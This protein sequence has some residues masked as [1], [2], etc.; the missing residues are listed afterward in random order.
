MEEYFAVDN[1]AA[2]AAAVAFAAAAFVA[3]AATAAAE[4]A[5]AVVAFVAIVEPELYSRRTDLRPS[6]LTVRSSA[7]AAAAV[8][9]SLAENPDDSDCHTAPTPTTEK[10]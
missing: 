2:V 10:S 5:L 1:V 6:H 8:A 3:V 9:A 7:A 4:Q